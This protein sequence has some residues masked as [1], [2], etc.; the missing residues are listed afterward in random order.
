[1]IRRQHFVQT[2][3][4]T[5]HHRR[6]F[7]FGSAI[8]LA[9]LLGAC[10]DDTS[11]ADGGDDTGADTGADTAVDTGD[12]T[13]TGPV[14]EPTWEPAIADDDRGAFMSVWGPSGDEV[15]TVGG[16]PTI[17]ELAGSR[18]AMRYDG[19]TWS[20]LEVPE[21]GMLN[22]VHGADGVVWMVGENGA[23]LR[24]EDGE[25][26]EEVDTGAGTNLWGIWCAR[27]DRCWAVGGNARDAES[28]P[29]LVELDG[30]NWSTVALPETER[31]A[32][33][34]FKIWGLDEDTIIAVGSVGLAYHYD[35]TTWTEGA[36][37]VGVDLI[38]LWGRGPNDIVAA[39]GRINGQLARW[40][41]TEWTTEV[42]GGV[43]GLN[44]VWMNRE[45]TA[46]SAGVNGRIVRVAAG[47]FEAEAMDSPAERVVHAVWGT[48]S[49]PFF[50]VGGS[51]DRNPPYVGEIVFAPGAE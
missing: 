2:P 34:L 36:T 37:G 19:S 45:G 39:G 24:F 8:A 14:V 20:D 42:L 29:V 28:T 48:D 44:G 16:Q 49:G 41:G 46:Y 40:D 10:G 25:F 6:F 35:G 26:V 33:A 1:M 4:I 12:D 31:P 11:D 51:L 38:S 7:I 13:T 22:W 32:R 5:M 21:G 50:A 3:R 23:A 9:G 30:T 43:P 27:A 47:T 15:Y 17:G 18:V